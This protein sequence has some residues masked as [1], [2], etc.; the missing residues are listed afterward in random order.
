M[1]KLS[2]KLDKPVA[3]YLRKSRAEEHLDITEVLNKHLHEL[4][5]TAHRHGLTVA[6]GDIYKEVAS[7]ESLYARPEMLRLLD[8]V[9][10]GS[11]SAVLCVDMQRLGRGGMSD[12]G[13]ILDT[14]KFS[15]TLIVTPDR[16]YDLSEE[17][18]EEAAE[19]QAMLSRREYKLITKRMRRGLKITAERG[20]YIANAP[21][22]Y[23]KVL[24]NKLPSLEPDENEAEIVKMIFKMYLAGDGCT[25]IASSLTELGICGKRG[26]N[27]NR[28]TVRNILLNPVYIGKIRW[29]NSIT[30]KTGSGK[31]RSGKKI[32]AQEHQRVYVDGCHPALISEELFY[33]ASQFISD[34]SA[35]TG[36]KRSPRNPF[37]GIVYCSVCG[38]RLQLLRDSKTG[39]YLVCPTRGCC[40][41]VRLEHFERVILSRLSELLYGFEIDFSE[42]DGL[43]DFSSRQK[44]MEVAEKELLKISKRKERLLCYLED[45]TIN[46]QTYKYRL[47]MAVKDEE[48][49]SS[50]IKKLRQEICVSDSR[51]CGAH[52]ISRFDFAQAYT[53]ADI[54]GKNQL[55]KTLI[56]RID[57]KKVK[58]S[59]PAD[60]GL[61][62][63]LNIFLQ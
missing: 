49:I 53:N 24:I 22:G 30:V 52:G 42:Y 55:L 39:D 37:A 11:Y 47:E 12:Q 33:L 57:Y 10:N 61:S 44:A 25:K 28:N 41:G 60:F 51:V 4:L 9:D 7:G 43:P 16:I 38:S 59:K 31:N 8:A 13:I 15:G 62:I 35:K 34:K 1:H 54:A 14:F 29:N 19:F 6:D 56:S 32:A 21:F 20:G 45:G 48:S 2:E 40:A 17:F 36:T 3:A 63:R 26:S 50:V 46:G 23:R 18:D 58:K 5:K 27:F